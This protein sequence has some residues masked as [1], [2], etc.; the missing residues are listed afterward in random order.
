MSSVQ[1]WRRA[2][3][4][5]QYATEVYELTKRLP[6]IFSSKPKKYNRIKDNIEGAADAALDS[7]L[8]ADTIH[9]DRFAREQD[10]LLRRKALQ[11]ARGKIRYVAV[12]S[13]SFLEAVRSGDYGAD[14]DKLPELSKIY[15]QMVEIG[16]RC[17]T[18]YNLIT[19]VLRSDTEIY[20]KFIRLKNRAEDKPE[21][22][23]KAPPPTGG[24]ARRTA[25]ATSATSTTT[26]ARTTTTPATPMGSRPSDISRTEAGQWSSDGA[27]QSP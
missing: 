9:M 19:G 25:R 7:V 11:T 1:T 15:D 21:T 13:F 24:S 12:K 22:A 4:K 10:Y 8:F 2:L 20:N 18:A 6:K 27:K 3:S 16:D 17:Q 5:T 23:L 14:V 26:E